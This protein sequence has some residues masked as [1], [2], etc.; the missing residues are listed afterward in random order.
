MHSMYVCTALIYHTST[1][2][3]KIIYVYS[4]YLIL[5]CIQYTTNKTHIHRH[6]SQIYIYIYICRLWHSI[7]MSHA[8]FHSP[9]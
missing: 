8:C 6:T 1:Y 4:I 7:I 2:M 3:H 5:V 9:G